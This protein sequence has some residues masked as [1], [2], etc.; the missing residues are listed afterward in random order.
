MVKWT[1]YRIPF[2]TENVII[3]ISKRD[4]IVLIKDLSDGHFK[5]NGF[6]NIDMYFKEKIK[7]KEAFLE[8][9]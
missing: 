7:R 6:R 8:A 5:R 4:D 2:S 3:K 9:V 1:F